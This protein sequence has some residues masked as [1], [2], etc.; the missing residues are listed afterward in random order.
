MLA[1]IWKKKYLQQIVSQYEYYLSDE[2]A[3]ILKAQV[4]VS[5]LFVISE[6][7]RLGISCES[8]ATWNANTY[9]IGYMQ[10]KNKTVAC[11]LA[12]AF[13]EYFFYIILFDSPLK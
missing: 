8:S 4:T 1:Y 10:N 9:F 7:I 3:L 13:S 6:E 12:P 5:E 2:N 11:R